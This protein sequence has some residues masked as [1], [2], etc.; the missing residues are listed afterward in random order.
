M[1]QLS[2]L[3][4]M[5]APMV[6]EAPDPV[7]EEK[8]REA[9]YQFCRTTR[10]WKA[11]VYPFMTVPHEAE[12]PVEVIIPGNARLYDILVLS[13]DNRPLDAGNF[14]RAQT[15]Q[16]RDPGTPKYYDFR[17]GGTTIK[18]YPT[19]NRAKEITGEV[20]LVPRMSTN[21]ID[22]RIFDDYWVGLREGTIF[23]LTSMTRKPWTDPEAAQ[24]AS[25]H[26]QRE[27][28]EAEDMADGRNRKKT[29]VTRY[30]GL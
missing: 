30:G 21:V 2:E 28:A 16:L 11:D 1:A 18:L 29:R 8:A 5:V 10:A 25:A 9:Y 20:I 6:P 12:V 3:V 26:F 15:P 14:R 17:A 13:Y 19:P 24:L 22:Q 27:M 23:L 4:A 7:I